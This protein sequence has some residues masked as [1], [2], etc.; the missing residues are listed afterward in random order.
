[1]HLKDYY[2]TLHCTPTASQQEIK[3]A[4]RQLAMKYHP[5]KNDGNELA[6]EH[7]KEIHEAYHTLSDP[8]RRSVYNQQRWYRHSIGKQAASAVLTPEDVLLRCKKLN[9]YVATLNDRINEKLLYRYLMQLLTE[10]TV[11]LLCRPPQNELNYQAISELL[12]AAKPLSYGYSGQ[13]AA[14][15]NRI[16]G[17]NAQMLAGI[18]HFLQEQK[19]AGYWRRYR[20][21]A[22]L[23]LTLMICLLIFAVSN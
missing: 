23:L 4:Y 17:G 15:L 19:V 14:Q 6:E 9:R 8:S 11:N 7:F 20:I 13:I 12:K 21:V 2:K 3:K 10:E 22:I 1:M 18:Q 5:D 16:A